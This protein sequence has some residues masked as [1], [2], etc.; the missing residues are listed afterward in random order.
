MNLQRSVLRYAT[1]V[2]A[3]IIGFAMIGANAFAQTKSAGKLKVA[4]VAVNLNSPTILR[5]KDAAEKD[6]KKRGWTV[7]VFDG[8]GDQVATNN[9]ANDFINRKFDAIINIASDNTQMAAVIKNANAAKIPFVSTFSGDV[10]GIDADIGA[11]SFVDGALAASELK[12]ALG[13][14]GHVVKMNWNVTRA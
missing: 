10:P 12:N 11:N 5:M 2:I 6:A 8:R 7:E 4:I 3:A 14:K 9:A 13:N 1:P